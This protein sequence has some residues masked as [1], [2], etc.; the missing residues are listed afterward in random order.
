MTS[1]ELEQEVQRLRE[2]NSQLRAENAG[3][4]STNAGLHH[5]IE[6]KT[7]E[8][9]AINDRVRAILTQVRE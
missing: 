1:E 2:E 3:W 8:L 6:R 9:R 4:Q 7:G 5:D